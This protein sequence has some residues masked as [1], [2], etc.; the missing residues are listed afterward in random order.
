MRIIAWDSAP[1]LTY[2]PYFLHSSPW[3]SGLDLPRYCRCLRVYP[4]GRSAK[5]ISTRV[6]SLYGVK[7]SRSLYP[8]ASPKTQFLLV[9]TEQVLI[10]S[11]AILSFDL[12]RNAQVANS[13]RLPQKHWIYLILWWHT[14]STFNSDMTQKACNNNIWYVIIS[15]S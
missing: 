5:G 6:C 8:C 14:N 15:P 1:N 10:F 2:P 9:Q 11:S 13:V 12:S 3:K 4:T 7:A